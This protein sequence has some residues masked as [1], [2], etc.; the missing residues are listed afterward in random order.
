MFSRVCMRLPGLRPVF[1]LSPRGKGQ[2]E[3]ENA[4][5][6]VGSVHLMFMAKWIS[7]HVNG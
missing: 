1:S 6:E 2:G 7:G 5:R 4:A 3:G